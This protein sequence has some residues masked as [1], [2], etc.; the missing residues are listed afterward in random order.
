MIAAFMKFTGLSKLWGYVA[1]AAGAIAL[2]ATAWF[3]AKNK[4]KVEERAEATEK[5]HEKAEKAA[6]VR[7]D[8]RS[9]PGKRD[10]VRKFDR[11]R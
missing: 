6:E 7:R 3:T 8:V 5:V 2:A 11:N 9:D 1:V 4:G 10:S